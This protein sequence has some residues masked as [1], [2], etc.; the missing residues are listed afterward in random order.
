[1]YVQMA[2][3]SLARLDG[4]GA[5]AVVRHW[6][7]IVARIKRA[8]YLTVPRDRCMRRWSGVCV[9][10]LEVPSMTVSRLVRCGVRCL[11]ALRQAVM[12]QEP[13]A[14]TQGRARCVPVGARCS[15]RTPWRFACPRRDAPAPAPQRACGGS[16]SDPDACDRGYVRRAV[17][18]SA[19]RGKSEC[20]GFGVGVGFGDRPRARPGQGTTGSRR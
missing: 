2:T 13:N 16:C 19:L 1:M 5:R 12:R 7:T 14:S 9:Q 3:Q 8:R 15:L 17:C 4:R 20:L 6:A 10:M 18:C 11:E